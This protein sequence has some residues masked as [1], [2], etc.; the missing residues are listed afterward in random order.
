MGALVLGSGAAA[1]KVR[2]SSAMKVADSGTGPDIIT[3]EAALDGLIEA[4]WMGETGMQTE[5]GRTGG[6]QAACSSTLEA[7]LP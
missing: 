6:E 3:G 1:A 5:E 7:A 4:A 2:K